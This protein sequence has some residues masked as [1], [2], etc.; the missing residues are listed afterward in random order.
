M[1][2]VPSP[3]LRPPS[4]ARAGEGAVV[5]LSA[6]E[7]RRR[8]VSHLGLARGVASTKKVLQRLRCIQLDPLDVI[9]T[10]ADLVVMARVEKARRGDVWRDLFPRHAFEHFAKER[11]ILRADAFPFYR[12]RGHAAQTPWW[13]H[14][15]REQRVPQAI[16]AAVLEEVR[17]HG[18][19]NAR[20]LTDHG[21]VDPIDWSGWKGTAKATSMALE[22]LWTRCDIVV[23]GRTESGA[24]LYDVPRR[25]LGA[26]A[27]EA[28]SE[29]FDR[30]ALRERAR[31]AGLLSRAG[32]SIWSMLSQVRISPLP[33]AMIE[34]GQLVDVSIEG[35]PRRYLAVPEFLRARITSPDDRVRILGPLDPLL[36]DRNL[37]RLL[38]DFEYVW[39]VYK[40]AKQRKWGWY[41]CPLLHRGQLVGRV[42]A[43]IRDN[44]LVV[45]KLW[46]ERDVD[47][48]LVH[49][50][51]EDHAARCGCRGV[52][53]ARRVVTRMM[54]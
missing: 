29:D 32:G 41:V 42:D 8:L 27:E 34:S 10:N 31:A 17:G 47:V 43:S 50:A 26:I 44:V 23:A 7:A 4:P 48:N 52:R 20:D 36:W 28:P 14:A 54:R 2:G 46:I 37:V 21:S 16:V 38:F 6:N 15:E 51:L 25:A 45:R 13:R 22:M 39:E 33:D 19:V 30:W 11:C 24:K 18:P 9:G 1:R 49:E 35:S 53:R 12:E 3:G 40:P 5:T